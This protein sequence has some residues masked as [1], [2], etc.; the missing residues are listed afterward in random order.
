MYCF[1][2]GEQLVI[3]LRRAKTYG[4]VRRKTRVEKN[5]HKKRN[6]FMKDGRK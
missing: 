4:K 1:Y 2:D 6:E 5:V 3:L